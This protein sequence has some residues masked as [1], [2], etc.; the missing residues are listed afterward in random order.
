MRLSFTKLDLYEFCPYAYRFR[1]VMR[2]PVPF[3]PRLTVGA[4]VHA[5]LKGLLVRLRDGLSATWDDLLALYERYWD[6]A[7]G[8]DRAR[9]GDIWERGNALLRGYWDANAHRLG[10]PI[11]LEARFTF[12]LASG[13]RGGAPTTAS[14]TVAGVVDRVD[15]LDDGVEILDY[16]SGRAPHALSPGV[17]TQLHTYALAVERRFGQR[18][19]L[20]TAYFLSD[21]RAR[22]LAPDDA[23]AE[24]L[25]ARYLAAGDA[26]VGG[27]FAPTPGPHCS[28]CD[29]TARCDFA[30][31]GE[32]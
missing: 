30:W 16:K 7:P 28:T 20:L 9:H 12:D 5:A 14:H 22:S 6:E 31:P 15:E 23:Y 10:R 27:R 29:Y 4:S 8:L 24:A 13:I 11:L 2:V 25:Q 32:K 26:I 17:L 3:A 19:R 1:Y 21:N 18:A